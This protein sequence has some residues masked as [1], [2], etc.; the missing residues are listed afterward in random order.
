M[1]TFESELSWREVEIY[2]DLWGESPPVSV[3]LERIE[4]MIEKKLGFRF[5]KTSPKL[6]ADQVVAKLAA[7][8]IG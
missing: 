6:S 2:L 5:N 7:L 3:T 8:G 4:K 1:R